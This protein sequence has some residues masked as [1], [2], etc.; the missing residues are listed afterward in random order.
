[1]VLLSFHLLQFQP[2]FLLS[3]N[4]SSP[5]TES[6]GVGVMLRQ[7]RAVC[8]L[9]VDPSYLPTLSQCLASDNACLQGAGDL[10]QRYNSSA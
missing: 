2:A 5:N 10:K 1:M 8:H 7:Q 9:S 6:L 4:W 3:C